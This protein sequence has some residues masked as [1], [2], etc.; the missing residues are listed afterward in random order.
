MPDKFDNGTR[1]KS[2]IPSSSLPPSIKVDQREN[3]RKLIH[4]RGRLKGRLTVIKNY[5]N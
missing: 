3:L 5:V 2:P 1:P 4:K